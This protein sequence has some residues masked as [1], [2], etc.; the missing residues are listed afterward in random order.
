MN[1]PMV[2]F[3]FVPAGTP[4]R[5]PCTAIHKFPHP[6]PLPKGEGAS[7][8]GALGDVKP[9]ADRCTS[10]AWQ[11]FGDVCTEAL[12]VFVAP[13]SVPVFF[14]GPAGTALYQLLVGG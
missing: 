13:A 8:L 9:I 12:A 11:K 6:N 14:P 7:G 2:D 4:D 5:V 3:S 1:P 10:T